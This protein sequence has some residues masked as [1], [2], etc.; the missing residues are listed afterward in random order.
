MGAIGLMNIQYVIL[1]RM[2]GE[3]RA[4]VYVLEVNPRSTRTVPFLSKVTGVPM[5]QLAVNAMLGR[6]LKRPGLRDGGLWP[7]RDLVAVKAPVFSMSK[8]VGVDTHLGPEM[9]STGEVMGIDRT[10]DAALAKALIASDLRPE[11]ERRHPPQH[12]RPDEGRRAAAHPAAAE[13]GCTALRDRGHEQDDRGPRHAGAAVTKVLSGSHPN[14]VDVVMDGTVQRVINTSEGLGTRA[15]F[16]TASTSA[17]PPPNSG[18]PASPRSTRPA[19]AIDALANPSEYEVLTLA[20]YVRMIIETAP[21][22]RTKRAVRRGHI[23]WFH[24]P[25]LTRRRPGQFVMVALQHR[26]HGPDVRAGVQLLPRRRRRFAVSSLSLAAAPRGSRSAR[27]ATLC[28][29]SDRCGN[30]FRPGAPSNLLLIGGGVGVAPLVDMAV[31]AVAAGHQVVAMMGGR[32]AAPALRERL[33]EGGGVC[34]RHR[35]RLRGAEEGFVTQH[36][37]KYQEWAE[38]DL[39]LRA[40]PDV[41][42][43]GGRVAEQWAAPVPGDPDGREHA[44]RLGDVLR[45][46]GLHEAPRGEALLQGRAAVQPLRRVLR[47]GPSTSA[48]NADMSIRAESPAAKGASGTWARFTLS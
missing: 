17:V 25:G 19:A 14:V 43:A 37:G 36:L 31:R 28:A 8:L 26:G 23:H 11:A 13:A 6:T 39:C 21:S 24:A 34:R 32:T 29:S 1:P 27:E 3:A 4:R 40:K 47:G 41:P 7:E 15:R 44:V 16:A 45:L 12:Q 2:P 48:Y 30:G 20:E 42:S 9:K 22:S 33:A 46:R 18:S 10:F 35:G 38:P 5:V